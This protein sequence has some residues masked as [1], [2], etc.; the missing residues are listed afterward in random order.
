MRLHVRH[1]ISR[2]SRELSASPN[3]GGSAFWAGS[4]RAAAV[5]DVEAVDLHLDEAAIRVRLKRGELASTDLVRVDGHWVSLTDFEPV[6]TEAQQA[7]ARERRT[8]TLKYLGLLL[9]LFL[10]FLLRLSTRLHW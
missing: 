10:A 9:L 5:M 3:R 4:D 1:L 7:A 6:A 2:V 8:R